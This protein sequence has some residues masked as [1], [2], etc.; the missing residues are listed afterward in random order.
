[1]NTTVNS[2]SGIAYSMGEIALD[3]SE[4]SGFGNIEIPNIPEL[5]GW[6]RFYKSEQSIFSLMAS[7][8]QKTFAKTDIAAK[9][10]GAVILCSA[11]FPNSYQS[12]TELAHDFLSSVG[13]TDAAC[14]GVTLLGC[15]NYLAGISL[16]NA[17]VSSGKYNN[18]LVVTGDVVPANEDRFKPYALFSDGASSCIVSRNSKIAEFEICAEASY[19]STVSMKPD[20]PFDGEIINRANDTLLSASNLTFSDIKF[21]MSNNLF[22]PIATQKE[23]EAGASSEQLFLSNVEHKGHCFAADIAIN[24]CDANESGSITSGD[25]V[26]LASDSPGNRFSL[27]VRKI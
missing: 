24:L 21:V 9:E 6:G 1:M 20:A 17:L 13:L 19:S 11:T 14:L 22:I 4:A 26:L 12:H 18:V 27:I 5:W 23:E 2:L 15:C 8:V 16:A 10:V 25:H 3:Y 7:S